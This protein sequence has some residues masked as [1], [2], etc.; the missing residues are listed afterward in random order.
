MV[1][2]DKDVLIS[3]FGERFN[4]T[5]LNILG[6]LDSN[7]KKDWK[8]HVAGLVYAYNC[9]RQPTTGLLPYF[10]MFGRTPRSPVEI[11]FGLEVEGK[12][13]AFC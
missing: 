1:G 5:L 11:T 12:K 2:Y 6:T 9:T 8:L 13:E 3:T 7:Q 10:L 4:R